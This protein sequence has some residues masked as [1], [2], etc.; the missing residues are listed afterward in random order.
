M[1]AAYFAVEAK[2]PGH[3]VIWAYNA[4]YFNM[5]KCDDPF[6]MKD[7]GKIYPPYLTPRIQMQSGAFTV[8]PNPG[9]PLDSV[10]PGGLSRI[11]IHKTFRDELKRTLSLYGINRASLFPDLDGL[12]AWV[13]W[14]LVR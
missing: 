5:D 14:E 2:H 10:D 1:I 6:K 12:S 11:I 7:V 13:E 3:R 4:P 8:H 9:V